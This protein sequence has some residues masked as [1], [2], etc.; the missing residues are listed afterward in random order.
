MWVCGSFLAEILQIFHS[1][2][3]TLNYFSTAKTIYNDDDISN[4]NTYCSAQF[5]IDYIVHVDKNKAFIWIL[6]SVTTQNYAIRLNGI[7]TERLTFDEINSYGKF[8]R[9]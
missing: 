9:E 4:S 5:R 2:F 6:V 8:Q 1:L 7:E 3:K